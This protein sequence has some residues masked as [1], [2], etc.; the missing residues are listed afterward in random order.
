MG[1][2][3]SREEPVEPEDMGNIMQMLPIPETDYMIAMTS[4][5]PFGTVRQKADIQKKFDF[6]KHK[7]QYDKMNEFVLEQIQHKQMVENYGLKEVWI[8]ENRHVPEQFHDKAKNNIFMSQE[9]AQ[10]DDPSQNNG[11]RALVL[12]Q[13]TGAVR[14]G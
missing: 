9:F 2:S 10:C 3:K 4:K 1:G 5:Y 6:V 11:K 7:T 13:G 12:I 14:A 8:P